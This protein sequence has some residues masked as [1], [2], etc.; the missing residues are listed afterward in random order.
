M[1]MRIASAGVELKSQLPWKRMSRALVEQ[2][3][4]M[5][6]YPEEVPFPGKEDSNAK[7]QKG[8]SGL[9]S[10]HVERLWYQIDHAKYPLSLK[11]L[12]AAEGQGNFII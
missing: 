12:S 9:S 6:N 3:M 2:A 5:L 11:N 10:D 8:I 1:T 4:I 7:S